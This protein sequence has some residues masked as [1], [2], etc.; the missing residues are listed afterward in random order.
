MRAFGA[1]RGSICR[2]L[3]AEGWCIAILAWIIGN[4]GTWFIAG[5]YGMTEHEYMADNKSQA[6][7]NI[8]PLWIDDFATHFWVI[9]AIVLV[10]LLVTV[11][12][13]VYIPARRIAGIS[14]VD[15]LRENN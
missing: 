7:N 11:T 6:L 14:P 15:A 1:T 12:I 5:I 13:G 9:S 3:I 2:N 4:I 10:L 8:I